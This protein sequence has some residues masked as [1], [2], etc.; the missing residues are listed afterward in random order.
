MKKKNPQSHLFIVTRPVH[1]KHF[2]FLVWPRLGEFVF[3]CVGGG[4]GGVLFG[5]ILAEVP[6]QDG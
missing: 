1:R 5:Y 3:V 2:F 6:L 4:G